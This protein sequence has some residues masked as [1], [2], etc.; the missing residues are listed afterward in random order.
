MMIILYLSTLPD[1]FD[2]PNLSITDHEHPPSIV[3]LLASFQ[4]HMLMRVNHRYHLR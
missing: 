4:I 1:R 3:I 2:E